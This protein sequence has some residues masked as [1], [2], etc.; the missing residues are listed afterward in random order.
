[1]H[2]LHNR[3]INFFVFLSLSFLHST[4]IK[5]HQSDTSGMYKTRAIVND[6]YDYDYDS[7]E[8]KKCCRDRQHTTQHTAHVHGT[9]K[10]L[11]DKQKKK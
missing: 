10:W 2:I 6:V 11:N 5:H 1:M 3:V 4:T 7:D 8:E 9:L